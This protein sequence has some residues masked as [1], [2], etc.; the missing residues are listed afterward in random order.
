MNKTI[1]VRVDRVYGRLVYYP[2][3]QAGV[4]FAAIS[5]HATLTPHTIAQAKQL[6]YTVEETKSDRLAELS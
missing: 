6:G 4:I 1:T 5:G 2:V 3:N